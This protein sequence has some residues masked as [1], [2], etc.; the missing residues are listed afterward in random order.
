MI[1]LFLSKKA[2]RMMTQTKNNTRT[3]KQKKNYSENTGKTFL[4][5]TKNTKF[6][7][8]ETSKK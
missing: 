5:T 6:S 7:I 4:G 2:C 8:Q 1:K 3:K